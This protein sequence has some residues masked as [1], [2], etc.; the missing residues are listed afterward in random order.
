VK[1]LLLILTG[2]LLLAGALSSP[3]KAK[4]D[5]DPDPQCL[6]HQMCKPGI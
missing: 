6:P 4:A 2:V 3:I 1:K 5:G